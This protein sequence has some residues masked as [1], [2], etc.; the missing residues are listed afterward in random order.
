MVYAPSEVSLLQFYENIEY[1]DPSKTYVG[2]SPIKV[3]R[4][5][6]PTN[7]LLTETALLD[8]KYLKVLYNGDEWYV[9]E[10]DVSKL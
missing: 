9:D 10:D 2:Q 5:K 7:L 3:V 1:S 4:L 8:K 6:V